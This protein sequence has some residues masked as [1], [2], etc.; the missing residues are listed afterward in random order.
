MTAILDRLPPALDPRRRLRRQSYLIFHIVMLAAGFI[1]PLFLAALAPVLPMA[2][3]PDN[4]E[5]VPALIAIGVVV[6][7]ALT[8]LELTVVARRCHDAGWTGWLCLI[9]LLPYVGFGFIL[10][11]LFV[12]G[13]KGPNRYGLDP[14]AEDDS[15]DPQ[16]A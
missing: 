1:L 9:A 5:E 10:L 14:R 16:A 11:M 15:T 3:L 13:T 8:L 2:A 12:P 7:L 6:G 4:P